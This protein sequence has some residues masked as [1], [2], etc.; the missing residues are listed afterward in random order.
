MIAAVA[1][2]VVNVMCVCDVAM[3]LKENSDDSQ[4]SVV[5]EI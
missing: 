5:V 4:L 3:D 1:V 2:V